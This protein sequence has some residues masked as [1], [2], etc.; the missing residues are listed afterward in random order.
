MKF[1][2]SVVFPS[3]MKISYLPQGTRKRGA[4]PLL[5]QTRKQNDQDSSQTSN[6]NEQGEL[7]KKLKKMK[8]ADVVEVKTEIVE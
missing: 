8:K 1:L 7:E 2:L 6:L 5:I 3:G 4:L